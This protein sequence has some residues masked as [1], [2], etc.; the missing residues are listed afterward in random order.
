MMEKG[1]GGEADT[2][3]REALGLE[4]DFK[5]RNT[6]ALLIEESLAILKDP[7]GKRLNFQLPWRTL[8]SSGE[9]AKVD[10]EPVAAEE[11]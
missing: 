8:Y 2:V 6:L 3:E 9:L 10:I 7:A 1:E 4:K 11:R 5:M